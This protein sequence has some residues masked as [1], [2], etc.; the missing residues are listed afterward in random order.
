MQHVLP[1]PERVSSRRRFSASSSSFCCSL[2]VLL[3][4]FLLSFF[5]SLQFLLGLAARSCVHTL[6]AHTRN[7]RPV[8]LCHLLVLFI[9]SSSY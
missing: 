5:F 9:H 3:V 8:F 6:C 7:L 1:Y 4:S 2:L